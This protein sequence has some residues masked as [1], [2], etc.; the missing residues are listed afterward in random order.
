VP[1]S[2]W[3]Q[4]VEVFETHPVFQRLPLDVYRLLFSERLCSDEIKMPL[5]LK[6]SLE[7]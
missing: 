5:E 6:E 1:E 7:I 2:A 3:A 4:N